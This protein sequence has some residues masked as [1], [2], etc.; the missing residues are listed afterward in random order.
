MEKAFCI[1][2]ANGHS[3][4]II[5]IIE[6]SGFTIIGLFDDDP[7]KKMIFEYLVSN[8]K[9]FL[10]LPESNW[11]IGIGNNETRKKIAENNL[12]N[13]ETIIDLSAN[14]SKRTKLGKGI[15]IMPGATVNSSS[16][17]GD[18]GIINTNSSIDH[19]CVLGDYV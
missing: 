10:D 8:K 18:H 4:V 17:I 2:G 15:V 12:L 6:R 5:E 11:I 14:V 19:D 7:T 1:Y 13:Y 9:S 3:K 16:I